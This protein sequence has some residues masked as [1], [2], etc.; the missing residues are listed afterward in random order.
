VIDR[1]TPALGEVSYFHIII[2]YGRC[3]DDKGLFLQT[4]VFFMEMLLF[5]PRFE[6]T[7]KIVEKTHPAIWPESYCKKKAISTKRALEA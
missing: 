1:P 4:P 2:P 3:Q 6:G 7:A 5:F